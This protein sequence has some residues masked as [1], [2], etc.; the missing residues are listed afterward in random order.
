MKKNELLYQKLTAQPH[1]PLGFFPTPLYRLDKLSNSLG[2]NIYIKR[3][4]FTGANTF[5]G[6]KIRK[7]EYLMGDA[8][9]KGCDTV[10]TFGATQSNHA[11]QTATAA[12]ICGLHPILYLVDLVENDSPEMRANLL[13]DKIFGAEL[14]IEPSNGEDMSIGVERS[15]VAAAE[16]VAELESEGR[17]AYVI[18]TGGATPVGSSAYIGGY[19]EIQQQMRAIGQNM[20]YIFLASGTGGTLAGLSGANH[21]LGEETKII[22]IAVG[23]KNDDYCKTVASLATMALEHIGIDHAVPENAIFVDDHYYAPGYEKPSEMGNEAIRRLARA[24]G[25]LT[26][27][28]YSG[29]AFSGLIDY[30]ESGKIEPGSNVVFLHTGGATALFAEPEIIGTLTEK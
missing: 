23:V 25:I 7:L 18:P 29:K 5:G 24:E 4:D 16:K 20:D 2:V 10:I 9:M 14:H 28:V 19:L 30:V 21:Y 6:N 1:Q 13:L 11:M 15:R 3:D 27:P 17:K 8:V 12:R 22:G 26:D